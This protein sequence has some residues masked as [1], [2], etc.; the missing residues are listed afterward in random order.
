MDGSALLRFGNRPGPRRWVALGALLALGIGAC[1]VLDDEGDASYPETSVSAGGLGQ[2]VPNLALEAGPAGPTA[3]YEAIGEA[4][5]VL[6]FTGVDCPLGDLSMPRLNRLTETYR[7]QG[8]AFLGINS[9]LRD[10]AEDVAEHAERFEAAFPIFKD[11]GTEAADLLDVRRTCEVLVLD[12]AGRLRYRGAID[13]QYLLDSPH[14][15]APRAN[16]LADALEAVLNGREVAEALTTPLGCPIESDRQRPAVAEASFRELGE[17]TY[18][19]HV[20]PILQ[21]KCQGCHRPGQVGPF[22]LLTYEDAS[23]W[24]ISIE[25]V[26]SEGRMPPWH[27]DPRFGTF[28]N[29]QSLSPR[30]RAL[31]IAWYDQGTPL[32]DPEALPPPRRFSDQEWLIGE[33]DIVLEMDRDFQVP[34]DGVV[35]YQHFRV[36]TGFQ[37]DVWFQAAEAQPGAREVVHHIGVYVDEHDPRTIAPGPKVKPVVAGYFPGQQP[38]IYPQGVAK[39]IPAGVDLIFEVHYT[40]IGRAVTDRSRVGIR[41]ARGPVRHH[42][43]TLGISNRDLKIPPGA[44]DFPVRSSYMFPRDVHLLNFIPHMHL[45]GKDFRYT[46]VYPDGRYEVLL[47]VPNYRFDWQSVYRL[48][49]PKALPAG[50]RIDCLAHF[51]NSSNNP[52]NPDPKALV[53]W[54]EQSDEEMMIG[55][56]DYYEDLEEREPGRVARRPAGRAAE[57]R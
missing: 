28:S 18:A 3:L 53:T 48:A 25:E 42:A 20:A 1:W 17:V 44:K 35:R 36:P 15:A 21:S 34:A 40:P 39:K 31:L 47:S 41:L 32:G 46:V 50:T 54:G 33:P 52:A 10:S 26:V 8:V 9:N 27:A 24:A 30:E 5:T 22:S 23:A 56:I 57:P 37:E 11:R 43:I 12:A 14:R 38:A 51:D 4:A 16:Y 6:V 49:E 13:D 2:K 19:E 29:D 7:S 45:R 55:Y